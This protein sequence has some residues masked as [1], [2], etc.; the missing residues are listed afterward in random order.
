MKKMDLGTIAVSLVSTAVLFFVI[1]Y[2]FQ[3][4]KNKAEDR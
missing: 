3:A 2:S 4:G 1:G